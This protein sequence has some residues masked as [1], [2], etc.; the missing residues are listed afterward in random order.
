MNVEDCLPDLFLPLEKGLV[1]D[2][3]FDL[4]VV[5]FQIE[6]ERF[7]PFGLH[8]GLSG[9]FLHLVLEDDLTEDVHGEELGHRDHQIC[10]QNFAG[11]LVLDFLLILLH[12]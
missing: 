4:L 12:F 10:F 6:G 1:V 8:S 2:V 5:V 7:I 9:R 11:Q 3:E